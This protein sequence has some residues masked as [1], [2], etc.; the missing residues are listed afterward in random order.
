MKIIFFIITFIFMLFCSANAQVTL[1]TTTQINTGCNGNPCTYNGPKI[2]INEVMLAP[3]VGDGSI[4]GHGGGAAACKGEWIELYNPDICQ[5]IDISCF[6]LGNN[7][8]S[9]SNNSAKGGGFVIPNGTIV[10][11]RGFVVI[12]GVTAPPIPSALLIQNG[13]KTI[14]IVLDSNL[15]GNICLEIGAS[16]LW[17]PNSGG[18]FAFY[19][20]NG[21]PQ[22]AISWNINEQTVSCFS[23]IPCNPQV[24]TCGYNG[25]LLS[26]NNFPSAKKNYITSSNPGTTLGKSFRRMP[27]GG[28]WVNI[29]ALP[30]YGTCNDACIP[31]PVITCTGKAVVIASGGQPPY[32]YLWNDQQAT[33]NDTVIGLCAGTYTVVVKDANNQTATASVQIQNLELKATITT[34]AIICKGGNNGSAELTLINGKIPYHYNWSNGDTTST[35]HNLVAGNYLVTITDNNDCKLDTNI[36]LPDSPVV[37]TLSVNNPTICSRNSV[38]LTAVPSLPG[39]TYNWIQSGAHTASITVSPLTTTTYNILYNIVG[40][41]VKDSSTVIV[42]PTPVLIVDASS[43]TIIAEDSVVVTAKGGLSYVWNTGSITDTIIMYPMQDTVYCVT[44]SNNNGCF[45][46]KCLKIDVIGASTLYIPNTFTPNNDGKNDLFFVSSTNIKSFHILIFNRWGNL[47]FETNDV[48]V[49]WDGK[50][51]GDYVPDGIYT[52]SLLAIGD[53]GV[54]YRRLGT[55]TVLR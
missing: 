14:E 6:F 16:R 30:T 52:Y 47:L 12:R 22:D 23:C 20:N 10:P 44:A 39:G 18:W 29:P 54:Y 24:S 46:A 28:N 55:I 17:F 13:G 8:P 2:L 34:T 48:N 25:S 41:I 43:L 19:D 50:F 5:S 26:Y 37:P 27:D 45:D 31:P 7:A 1:S 11:P 51:N 3:L 49:G 21:I 53:D 33:Q 15:L 4:F 35:T 42:K 36:A 32:T 38:V 9:D 40:C